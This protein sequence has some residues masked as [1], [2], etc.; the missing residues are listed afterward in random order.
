VWA[1]GLA[2]EAGAD[3]AEAF[4]VADQTAGGL[5]SVT[6]VGAAELVNASGRVSLDESASGTDL[7][8]A[9]PAGEIEM[10]AAAHSVDE[11]CDSIAAAMTLSGE[12]IRVALGIAD[13][14]AMPYWQGIE[15]RLEARDDVVEIVRYRIG[16]SVGAFFGPGTAG[17]FWYAASA[18]Q[19]G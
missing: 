6:A 2:I 9:N 5:Y 15:Q 19:T 13:K 8:T 12:P 4:A 10:L 11:A 16:P 7:F 18:S 1:A 17:G 14:S 3:A